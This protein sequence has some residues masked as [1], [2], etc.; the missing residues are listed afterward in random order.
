[1]YIFLK[2][3]KCT[4]SQKQFTWLKD[5]VFDIKNQTDFLS[6]GGLEKKNLVNKT[7]E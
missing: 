2:L 6:N 4:D 5:Y 3:V 7:K 1:M